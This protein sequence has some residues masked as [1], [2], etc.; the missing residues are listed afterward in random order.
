MNKRWVNISVLA[1]LVD[2]E[3]LGE[4]VAVHGL[5]DV[6]SAVTGQLAYIDKSR[7]IA[8]AAATRASALIVPLTAGELA[9][10]VIRVADPTW[11]AAV[12]HHYL[13]AEEF[14]AAGIDP[15]VVVGADCSIPENVT[16]GA[17]VVIGERAEI[18][19]R[20]K[21]CPGVVIGDDVKLG[22]DVLIHPNVTILDR[23]LVGDRVII[24]SGAVLGS[25]GFGYA[26]DRAGRHV[27]RPQVGFVQIDDDVEIGANSCVD[28]ATFGRTWIKRGTKIDNLVQIGH[29]V[30]IG[31]DSIIVSQSGIAGSTILGD[32][33]V[34][35]GK[36]AVNGHLRIGNRVTM[37][38]KAG[39]MN[40]QEDGAVVAGF[41]AFPHKKWL[42]SV[43]IFQK[44]PDL[45]RE[46]REMKNKLNDLVKNLTGE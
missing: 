28:R 21:I 8:A 1:A 33:V 31:E 40:N 43:A 3:W 39:V 41:P 4:D 45:A 25:D 46:V 32:G 37:A 17:R 29:N 26:H 9:L 13:L 44:L 18:G 7:R 16:I 24:H 14:V 12:I 35:G 19:Q 27:K 2:G 22:S 5:A 23:V 11:A 10:P 15:S 42:R 36:V 38:G 30:E 6:N 34:M 20:V